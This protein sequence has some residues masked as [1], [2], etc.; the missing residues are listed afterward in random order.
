MVGLA[1]V[2][3]ESITVYD[4]L[5]EKPDYSRTSHVSKSEAAGL[6]ITSAQVPFTCTGVQQAHYCPKRRLRF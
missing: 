4:W 2:L 6:V 1:E 5:G 3:V